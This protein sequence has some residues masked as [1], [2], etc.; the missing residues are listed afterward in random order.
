[1]D[2]FN[3]ITIVRLLAA[4]VIA[5]GMCYFL[6]LKFVSENSQELIAILGFIMASILPTMILAASSIRPGS[7]SPLRVTKYADAVY[8]QIKTWA[9]I[10]VLS[11][12]PC[13]IIIVIKSIKDKEIFTESSSTLYLGISIS[14]FGYM[15][16]FAVIFLFVFVIFR[17]QSLF[18]GILDLVDQTRVLSVEEAAERIVSSMPSEPSVTTERRI[19]AEGGRISGKRKTS[20]QR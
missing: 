8:D 10:F 3:I 1:M 18:R 12:L 16:N 6:P 7:M 13:V 2:Q 4:A 9:G 20:S 11:I 19:I 5:V 14:Y 15:I 17:V